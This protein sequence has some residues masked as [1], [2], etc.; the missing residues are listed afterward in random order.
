MT[1]NASTIRQVQGGIEPIIMAVRR[2]L[3]SAQHL[4]SVISWSVL[5]IQRMAEDGDIVGGRPS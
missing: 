4:R 3:I 5:G 2:V 1:V